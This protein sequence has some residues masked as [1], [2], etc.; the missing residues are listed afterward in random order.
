[1]AK[2]FLQIPI[3]TELITSQK[4]LKRCSLNDSV[5]DMIRLITITH[6]GENKEDESFGNELWDNDFE[7]I[8]NIQAFKERLA[9]SLHKA[10]IQHEKRLGSVK[11][12]VGF[13]QVLTKVLN[14]R[15]RQRIQITIEG[16][17]RKTN[18]S[19]THSEVFFM[20]PLSYY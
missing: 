15:V 9:E 18:E 17:L 14:K 6:F 10:V 2:D 11:V 16:T 12:I 19:F 7:T 13:E 4:Q 8:D 20:G 1:M 5:A 3:Q